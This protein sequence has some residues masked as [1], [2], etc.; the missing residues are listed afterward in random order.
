MVHIVHPHIDQ[1]NLEMLVLNSKKNSIY[2]RLLLVIR[3]KNTS[4]GEFEVSFEEFGDSKFNALD[5]FFSNR[6]DI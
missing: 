3:E 4:F 5:E 1:S 2:F 6:L